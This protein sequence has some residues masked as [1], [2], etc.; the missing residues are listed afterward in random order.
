LRTAMIKVSGILAGE[1]RELSYSPSRYE[2][3]YLANYSGQP[4]SLTMPTSKTKF[5]FDNFPPFF[6]GLLPEGIQLEILLRAY[7]LDR[8]DYFGQ[9]LA[10]GTDLV[11]NV[12]AEQ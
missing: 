7:K 8:S 5:N 6:E 10:V 11:G 2:F 3:E 9:L 4:V 12:T 1:L